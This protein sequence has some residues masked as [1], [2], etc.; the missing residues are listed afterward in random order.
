MNSS[1]AKV[2]I[3]DTQRPISFTVRVIREE[4]ITILLLLLTIWTTPLFAQAASEHFISFEEFVSTTEAA[5]IA[6]FLDRPGTEATDPAA[7]DEMRRHVLDLYIGVEVNHSFLLDSDYIDCVP[8]EQQPSARDLEV[9]TPSSLHERSVISN[10]L[11]ASGL[12]VDREDQPRTGWQVQPHGGVDQFGNL[13][14]CQQNTIPMRRLTLDELTRFR[15]LPDFFQRVPGPATAVDGAEHKYATAYQWVDNVGADADLNV[16]NPDVRTD[17]GEAVSISQIWVSGG[18]GDKHQVVE[19]GWENYPKKYGDNN[20][21]LFINWTP[22]N[23]KTRCRNLEC[24]AFVQLDDS[25][26]LGG[27]FDAYST[28][29]GKQVYVNIRWAF[30]SPAVADRDGWHLFI[31][32]KDVGYYPLKLFGSGQMSK[33]AKLIQFGGE[34]AI[35]RE[36]DAKEYWPQMGSG[37]WPDKGEG[38]AASQRDILYMVWNK[39]HDVLD[40]KTP[41]LT[42][43][44]KS[45]KCYK[46]SNP[47]MSSEKKWG[48]YFFFGGPGSLSGCG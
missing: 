37:E 41:D 7:F 12:P 15:T 40:Y 45:P 8:I 25:V 24:K 13:Q 11:D 43:S 10:S 29:G 27:K 26:I 1:N 46:I 4:I 17:F 16:W 48:T 32:D 44:Q 36:A 6:D 20:S 22:D 35:R 14:G 42:T 5:S 19:G 30:I 31:G 3:E 9:I 2:G 47:K 28:K 18:D 39:D 21:R 34:T 33:G 23:Y 38:Q